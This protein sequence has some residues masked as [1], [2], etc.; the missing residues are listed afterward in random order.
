MEG[1]R[2][3]FPIISF[4]YTSEQ[5]LVWTDTLQSTSRFETISLAR[6]NDTPLV[7]EKERA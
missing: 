6:R 4:M 7:M 5:G 1:S 2:P 3:L